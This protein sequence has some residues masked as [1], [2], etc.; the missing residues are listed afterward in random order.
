MSITAHDLEVMFEEMRAAFQPGDVMQ[1]AS[2]VGGNVIAGLPAA[3]RNAKSMT[4]ML[5]GKGMAAGAS[6]L[7]TAGAA[8]DAPTGSQSRPMHVEMGQQTIRNLAEKLSQAQ[9]G[10]QQSLLKEFLGGF[11]RGSA[12][13][14]QFSPAHLAKE[15]LGKKVRGL[16]GGKE[17]VE[18]ESAV[19]SSNKIMDMARQNAMRIAEVATSTKQMGA[20]EDPFGL[21]AKAI[22]QKQLAGKV[23]KEDQLSGA[24][25]VA[26]GG[27]S[28]T[29]PA[30]P[31][32][33][34]GGATEAAAGL[35]GLGEAAGALT[36]G[37]VTG[38]LVFAELAAETW[39]VLSAMKAFGEATVEGNRHLAKFSGVLAVTQAQYD[40]ATLRR[41]IQMGQATGGS[42]ATVA[43]STMNLQ[44][45]WQPIAEDLATIKNL[46]A[47]VVVELAREVTSILRLANMVVHPLLQAIEMFLGSGKGEMPIS[48][49]RDFLVGRN[50]A[51]TRDE[52]RQAQANYQW[53]AVKPQRG[54]IGAAV[55]GVVGG[56]ANAISPAVGAAVT[57]AEIADLLS[58]LKD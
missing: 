44:E 38:I 5:G 51:A 26:K 37:I 18:P 46:T 35:L 54:A 31:P 56:A 14:G 7:S 58:I 52:R 32:A 55:H 43:Q 10:G 33:A 3:T 30:P 45:E 40:I 42:A 25:R 24:G 9:R 27:F 28:S 34:A 13:A 21:A 36:G 11:S 47:T 12:A 19:A 4:A 17:E 16:L 23:S 41:E 20:G 15:W 49:L 22:Q 48:I 57:A 29:L 53:K 8:G 2:N 39:A 50:L 1:A 6:A